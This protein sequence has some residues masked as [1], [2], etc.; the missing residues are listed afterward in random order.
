MSEKGDDNQVLRYESMRDLDHTRQALLDAGARI[1]AEKGLAGTRIDDLVS[2]S[3]GVN[4]SMIYYIFGSKH[5]LYR[6]VLK[7]ILVHL[8]EDA[9]GTLSPDRVD[10]GQNL[11]QASIMVMF[12]T[13]SAK[14][15]WARLLLRE[16]L[17]GGTDLRAVAADIP[18]F[19]MPKKIAISLLQQVEGNA[20]F[21]DDNAYAFILFVQM[22]PM[23]LPIVDP[24][25]DLLFPDG[26]HGNISKESWRSFLIQVLDR[27]REAPGSVAD[28]PNG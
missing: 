9:L 23:I 15:D 13:F 6:E 19:H 24:I 16:V 5:D 21:K 3:G 17:D 2:A 27:F 25:L 1:F 18:N 10:L 22:M 12:E 20:L 7:S 4:R 28:T 26:M 8:R 11:L 14:P